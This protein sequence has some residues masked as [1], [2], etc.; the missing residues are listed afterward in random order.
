VKVRL[1]FSASK[2]RERSS[3][4]DMQSV[5]RT[6]ELLVSGRSGVR[7]VIKVIH[8]PGTTDQEVIVELG[9]AEAG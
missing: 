6:G 8:T 4:V 2:Q 7:E 5:P 1:V 9:P 3:V